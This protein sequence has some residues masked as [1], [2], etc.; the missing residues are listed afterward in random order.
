[1]TYAEVVEKLQHAQ[2]ERVERDDRLLDIF[3]YETREKGVE[4]WTKWTKDMVLCIKIRLPYDSKKI[5]TYEFIRSDIEQYLMNNSVQ[6]LA[7][8][9]GKYQ[10]E[11]AIQT[12]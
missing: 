9:P 7:S 2:F 4:L 12:I 1:M 3:P 6:D 8:F 5:Y 11:A 10:A